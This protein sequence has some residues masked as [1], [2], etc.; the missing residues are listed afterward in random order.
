[1]KLGMQ[2]TS[3]V[4]ASGDSGVSGSPGEGGN[5][6][7]CLGTGQIFA[8]YVNFLFLFTD[9]LRRTLQESSSGVWLLRHLKLFLGIQY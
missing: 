8:P 1:M 6:D 2:G 5:A 4:V 9:F 7:G 3:V